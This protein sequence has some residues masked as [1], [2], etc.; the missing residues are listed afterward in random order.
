LTTAPIL[1]AS[2][3]ANIYVGDD[4]GYVHKLNST[5]GLIWKHKLNG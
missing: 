4:S 3:P 1:D 5:G 2:N